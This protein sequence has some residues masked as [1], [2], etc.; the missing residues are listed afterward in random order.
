MRDYALEVSKNPAKD[1]VIIVS[2]GPERPEDNPAELARLEKQA[3]VIRNTSKFTDVKVLSIEDDAIPEVRAARLAELRGM[4]QE[5]TDEGR[6]VVIVPLIL[7]RG[8][9]H[10]RL[11]KD[12]TGL[13]Y[14]FANRGLIEHPLFQEWIVARV[15][16]ATGSKAPG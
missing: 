15:N 13:T 14:N 2:H 6:E 7:T 11:Q 5:A 1:R 16:E 12:L 3:A 8:G 4:V 9:F 10:A